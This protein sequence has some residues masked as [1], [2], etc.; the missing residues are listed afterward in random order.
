[1]KKKKIPISKIALAGLI[2]FIL[3]II[4]FILVVAMYSP[5]FFLLLFIS[6]PLFWKSIRYFNTIEETKSI[7]SSLI[8]FWGIFVIILI[9]FYIF[10][11]LIVKT[12]NLNIDT[13]CPDRDVYPEGSIKNALYELCSSGKSFIGVFAMVIILHIIS[14]WVARFVGSRYLK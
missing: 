11:P 3:F 8:K 9:A 7:I 5:L 2:A 6:V 1:M 10:A 12:L 14:L 4:P 13:G